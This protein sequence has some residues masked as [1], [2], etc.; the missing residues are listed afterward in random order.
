MIRLISSGT[1]RSDVLL[2]ALVK[3]A[4]D[5]L[6]A[7]DAAICQRRFGDA[8]SYNTARDRAFQR[9]ERILLQADREGIIDGSGERELLGV[10]FDAVTLVRWALDPL[11]YKEVPSRTDQ[12]T[13]LDCALRKTWT[14][15]RGARL[16]RRVG[17]ALR[18]VS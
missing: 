13:S 5:L 7:T 2:A 11:H 17:R 3:A 8:G 15:A 4:T 14:M 12:T 10:V 16:G 9:V 6:W 18:L 1:T